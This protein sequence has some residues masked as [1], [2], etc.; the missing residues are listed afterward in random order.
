MKIKLLLLISIFF[1]GCSTTI[2]VPVTSPIPVPDKATII[3]IYNGLGVYETHKTKVFVDDKIIGE[4]NTMSPLTVNVSPGQHKL[5]TETAGQVIDRITTSYFEQ[6][7]IYYMS[8]WF[9]GGM[10]AGSMWISEIPKISEFEVIKY[11]FQ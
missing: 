1:T 6:N 3:F 9:E 11:P 8:I 10:W 2:K 5:Y 7:K 4:I